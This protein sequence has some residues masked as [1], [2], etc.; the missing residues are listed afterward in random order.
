[1]NSPD[2]AR[3]VSIK[4]EAEDVKQEAED[5]KQEAEDIKQEAEDQPH[6]SRFPV[7]FFSLMFSVL[8]Q[9]LLFT[10]LVKEKRK[11]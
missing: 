11:H 2:S 6:L 1:M 8:P 9:C 3:D 4:Q 10:T 5:I 7:L